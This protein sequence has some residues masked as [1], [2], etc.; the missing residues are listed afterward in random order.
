MGNEAKAEKRDFVTNAGRL[1]GSER[2]R[3]EMRKREKRG[4]GNARDLGFTRRVSGA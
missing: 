1:G 2:V 3:N 4:G